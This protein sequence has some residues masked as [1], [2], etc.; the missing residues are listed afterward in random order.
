[1]F[2]LYFYFI[3]SIL[4]N[5]YEV[6]QVREMSIILCLKLFVLINSNLYIFIHVIATI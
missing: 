2:H 6:C 1:M 4:D 5:I 3:V